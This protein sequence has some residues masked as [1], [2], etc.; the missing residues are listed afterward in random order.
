MGILGKSSGVFGYLMGVLGYLMGVLGYLMGVPIKYPR[1]PIKYPKTPQAVGRHFRG[2]VE[3][4][5][6]PHVNP[7]G[8]GGAGR[9]LHLR[10]FVLPHQY[11]GIPG[12]SRDCLG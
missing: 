12:S 9:H 7:G 3:G 2:G 11:P 1:T 5:Q 4:Q 10:L 6:P 8:S